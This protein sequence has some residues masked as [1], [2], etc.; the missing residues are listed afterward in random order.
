MITVDV[1]ELRI[2]IRWRIYTYDYLSYLGTDFT[3][4]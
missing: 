2:V 1:S 4:Q 3:E